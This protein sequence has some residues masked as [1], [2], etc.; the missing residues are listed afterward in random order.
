M[1]QD[2]ILILFSQKKQ[3]I[4]LKNIYRHVL[5]TLQILSKG[6]GL[7]VF[8]LGLAS[9]SLPQVRVKRAFVLFS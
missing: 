5:T 8:L 6:K 3:G 9:N 7:V 1:L 2:N 4:K